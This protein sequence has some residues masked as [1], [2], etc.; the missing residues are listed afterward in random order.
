[1]TVISDLQPVVAVQPIASQLTSE[2]PADRRLAFTGDWAQFC[3]IQQG[4]VQNPHIRL[5]YFENAIEIVMPGWNHEVFA[6]MIGSLLNIFL[7]VRGILFFPTGSMTQEKESQTSLQP[8]KS[9]CIESRKD[10]PDL[11]V[12]VTVTSGGLQKLALYDRLEISEVWFWDDGA[13]MVYRRRE[14]GSVYGYDRIFKSEL[15]ALQDLDLDLFNRC[16][17]MAET[18]PSEGIRQFISAIDS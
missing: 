9:Y 12:E 5:S 16:V 10:R 3:L 14:A 15:P 7:S 6:E 18:N 1:M 8:D 4:M 17:L 13:L 11:A 2:R